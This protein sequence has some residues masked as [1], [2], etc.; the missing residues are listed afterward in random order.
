MYPLYD[1][2]TIEL[3]EAEEEAAR[4][5]AEAE[6]FA[7]MVEAAELRRAESE[8]ARKPAPKDE[9]LDLL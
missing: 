2:E 4:E 1:T 7:A 9:Y 8:A 3:S 5:Q 6:A